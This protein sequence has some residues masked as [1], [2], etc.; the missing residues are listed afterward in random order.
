MVPKIDNNIKYLLFY[1][2]DSTIK[3]AIHKKVIAQ[4]KSNWKMMTFILFFLSP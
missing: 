4:I 3:R 1:N 2:S